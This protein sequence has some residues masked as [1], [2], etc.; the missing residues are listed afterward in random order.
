MGIRKEGTIG[1]LGEIRK[2]GEEGEGENR[3][4]KVWMKW[5]EN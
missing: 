1:V 5:V 3:K 4:D 2:E